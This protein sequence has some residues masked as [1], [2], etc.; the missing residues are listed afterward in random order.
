MT[1][2][3]RIAP[4]L[5]VSNLKMSLQYYKERLGFSVGLE[6]AGGNYAIVERDNVAIH[7]FEDGQRH[8]PVAMHIFTQG[9]EELHADLVQRGAHITQAILN[10][11]WGTRDFRVRDDSGNE[12]KFTES[13]PASR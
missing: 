13:L 10:K 9:L 12:I 11:P 6:I 4:E 3:L 2:L 5:P 7:L 1:K 8:S